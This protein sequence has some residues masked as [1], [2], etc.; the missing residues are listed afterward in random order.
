[1]AGSANSGPRGPSPRGLL[2]QLGAEPAALGL[3]QRK[4]LGGQDVG[5]PVLDGCLER[6]GLGPEQSILLEVRDDPGV[7]FGLEVD[8]LRARIGCRRL[9]RAI[10]GV[11]TRLG[12]TD[13][14]TRRSSSEE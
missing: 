9:A 8:E 5:D 4:V 13:R 11:H 1:M 7:Q 10:G 6:L 12:P 2:G 14:R 3:V